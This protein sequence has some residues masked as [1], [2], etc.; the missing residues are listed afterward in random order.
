MPSHNSA[1]ATRLVRALALCLLFL[2]SVSPLAVLPSRDHAEGAFAQSAVQDAAKIE[3]YQALL[4]LTSPWTVMC[5]AAHPDDEDGFTLT[6]LRHKYGVHTVSLFSTFG[7]GGQNAIGPELYEELGAIRARE[8]SEAAAIQG[9]EPHFLGLRDFGFS[10]SADEAFKIWGHDEAL[11]RMVLQIRTLRPDVIITNHDTVSG[12]GHHQA[13]GRL[14]IEAFD[15]SAN[16]A[17]FPEQLREA[18]VT[19]WQPKRLFVRLFSRGG[20]G[21]AAPESGV[22]VI[23][24]NEMDPLRGSTYAEQA[25]QALRRHA[26]Q[27]PWPQKLPPGGASIIRYRLVKEASGAAP[28][29]ATAATPLDGLQ[30]P[31]SEAAS[32][33]PPVVDGKP[34]TDFAGQPGRVLDAL[35]AARRAGTYESTPAGDDAARFTMM[36]GRLDHALALAS[37]VSIKITPRDAALVPNISTGFSV[38]VSNSG[39]RAV[40]AARAEFGLDGSRKIP[41]KAS[42]SLP[43]GKNLEF[44]I[45]REVPG[46]TPI[47][48]PHAEHLYDGLLWGEP[49]VASAM[50][51]L[52]GASFRVASTKRMD[53]APPIEILGLDPSPLVLTP[54]TIERPVELTARLLS[55]VRTAFEV[56]LAPGAGP[57]YDPQPGPQFT[58]NYGET[59]EVLIRANSSGSRFLGKLQAVGAR[60][61][62]LRYDVVESSSGK[63]V[64]SKSVPVVFADARVAPGIRV[65]YFR[66]FDYSLPN[67]LA[68]LGVDAHELTVEDARSANLQ[69]YDTII[70]DNRG[71][72]AHPE[73]I[74]ANARLLEYVRAGGTLVVFYHKSNEWNPDP[75]R[76]RPQLAPYALT[77]GNSRVTDEDAPVA[78]TDPAQPLLN[79]PNRI[80]ADDFKGWVQERGL[81]YPENWDNRYSN[82]LSTGDPGEPVLKGGLLAA[83]YGRGK[84][85]YTSMV[86]YRQLRAGVPG[87]YRMLANMISY[88]HGGR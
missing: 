29:P 83:D 55:H 62:D 25:L 84:Y 82:P 66:S 1:L 48:V 43:P 42:G 33:A 46:T 88:G 53:V 38:V 37:G 59:R 77:L 52:E 75:A 36:R 5:V 65:G 63:S 34:L 16:P 10:K 9:S 54:G 76:N 87:G 51:E 57:A 79:V 80:T 64:A 72:E 18:G 30:L 78:V 86:W 14:V 22:V 40:R 6:M 21:A 61:P 2:F 8:T 47:N 32:L 69:S 50:I 49:C 44:S 11:R 26:T 13:T 4:D 23:N 15:A 28:L 20:T 3:R 73:L 39:D 58:L 74:A 12:H 60:R 68:A 41:L 24:P 81:Y 7:E 45:D 85:I 19:T 35:I 17:R 70:I 27:G 71:Y 31:G 67:A 56:R